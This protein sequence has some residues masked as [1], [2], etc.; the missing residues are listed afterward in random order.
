MTQMPFRPIPYAFGAC[1]LAWY[2]TPHPVVDRLLPCLP[3]SLPLS[4]SPRYRQCLTHVNPTVPIS[5]Y[6]NTY[7]VC[8]RTLPLAS[9]TPCKFICICMCDGKPFQNNEWTVMC[10]LRSTYLVLRLSNSASYSAVRITVHSLHF[11]CIIQPHSKHVYNYPTFHPPKNISQQTTKT[12]CLPITLFSTYILFTPVRHH[13]LFTC[14]SRICP[15]ANTF[16]NAFQ[17]TRSDTLARHVR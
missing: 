15:Y 4:R 16:A 17:Q 1:S 3:L 14:V 10:H 12:A 7:A 11:H 2:N 13:P 9:P 8:P 5:T 6:P